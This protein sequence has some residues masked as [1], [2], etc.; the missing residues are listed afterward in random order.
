MQSRLDEWANTRAIIR[1]T[2]STSI[3]SNRQRRLAMKKL[4]NLFL[5]FCTATLVAQGVI[6]GLSYSVEISRES[7]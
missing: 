7:R 2:G 5:W 6:L 4:F 3:S 1:P